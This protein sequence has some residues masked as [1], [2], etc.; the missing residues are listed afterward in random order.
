MNLDFVR[1][2]CQDYSKATSEAARR[3]ALA[4]IAIVWLL[5]D[6]D[7]EE[8]L[9]FL[10]IWFFLICLC[11][12]FVQYVWG[13]TSWLIFD[14]VK[15]NALQ[16]KYGDDGASIEEADFEAPFWMNYPTNFFFFLKIVFVSIG[17]YFLL[18]DVT[19]LI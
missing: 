11:F 2:E 7:K 17:Y 5:A 9:N 3:L 12:E 19:H 18:V 10:P 4:G 16:D 14:Y 15:E 13:Y 1:Q 8:V 6:K